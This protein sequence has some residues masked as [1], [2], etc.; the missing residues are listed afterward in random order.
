[1][2]YDVYHRRDDGEIV[3]GQVH[4]FD[5][6]SRSNVSVGAGLHPS[7]APGGSEVAVRTEAGID[8]VDVRTGTRRKFFTRDSRLIPT[9]SPDGRWM[10]YSRRGTPKSF[11]DGATEPQTIVIRDIRTGAEMTLGDVPG[12]ANPMDYTWVT[13]AKLCE[14]TGGE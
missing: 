1:L 8:L 5:I 13:N 14:G 7:W 10:V 3:D 12:K 6:S 2:A 11:L 9:W 4:V